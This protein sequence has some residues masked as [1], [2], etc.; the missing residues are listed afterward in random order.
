MRLTTYTI[1][2]FQKDKLATLANAAPLKLIDYDNL[3]DV[4]V[5][6][7]SEYE[8]RNEGDEFNYL[9][10]SMLR[11]KKN[12]FANYPSSVSFQLPSIVCMGSEA[13]NMEGSILDKS[14]YVL[15][16]GDVSGFV[17]LLNNGGNIYLEGNDT[18]AFDM[19]T[20]LHPMFGLIGVSPNPA[21]TDLYKNE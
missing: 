5:K 12:I 2:K 4:G 18:W 21:L 13:E 8:D 7:L 9:I 1:V 15:Q 14:N 17:S 10:S 11:F 19:Q 3:M 16:E 20:S 6:Y